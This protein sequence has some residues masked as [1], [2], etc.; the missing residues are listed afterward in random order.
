M[1]GCFTWAFAATSAA[2]VSNIIG[3]GRKD[4]VQFLIRKIVKISTGV[5]LL[6]GIVINIFP[7][8]LLSVFGQDH[9]FIIAAIP[10]VRIVT[11]AMVF[12]SFSVIW[13][14]AVTGTG[15][16]RITFL[17]ELF[18]ILLY[19]IYIFV[20]LEKYFLSITY[21]WMSEWLYWICMFSLSFLYI[22]SGKWKG[23]MI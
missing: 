14:N 9:S 5:A 23:K 22:R 3:Q 16:S 6:I 18:C 7:T 4:E 19:C 20:V 13:L 12:M 2:M 17:I 21:G 11:T 10:V 15:N 1:V 8:Q